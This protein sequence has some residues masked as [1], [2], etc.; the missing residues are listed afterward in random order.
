MTENKCAR[1]EGR[2]YIPESLLNRF[3]KVL[4]FNTDLKRCP[5][6]GGTGKD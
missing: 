6:C 1:C 2:G 5:N 4:M 3:V